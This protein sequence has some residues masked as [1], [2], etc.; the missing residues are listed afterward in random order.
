MNG[1]TV[2]ICMA[3]YNGEAYIREQIDSILK[4]TYTN[5]VLFIRDDDSSDKTA[6]IIRHYA[7]GYP[8]K[9]VSIT[10]ESLVGGSAKRNFAAVLSWVSRN[11]DFSYFMFA[12]QDDVWLE[13][14]IEISLD[15]MKRQESEGAMPL[16]VHTDLTVVDQ[17]LAVLGE[18]FFQYRS[19]DPDVVDL[20]HLL[21]QNNVTGCTMLWNRA[22]NDLLDLQDARV[23]MHDWWIALAACVFGKILCLHTPTILYRQ[24]QKNVVG[25][26]K[27]NSLAFI[28][29]RLLQLS[30][31]R[32][33]LRQAVEQ[34]GAFLS[35]YGDRLKEEQHRIIQTFSELYTHNKLI[36]VITVLKGPFLKQGLIQMIGELLFI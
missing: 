32:K 13:N 36:R 12:D 27:V 20:P 19:L 6:E 28:G 22:L 16:L 11:Y 15:L 2:A 7:S 3:T 17:D 35:C 30:H 4:Q 25:A 1:S 31:V 34:A 10:D 18:S 26:T 23:V 21:I 24:H 33:T 8:E 14:K 9:I 29:R 5:W